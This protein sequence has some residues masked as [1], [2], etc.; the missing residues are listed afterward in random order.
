MTHQPTRPQNNLI[1]FRPR[2]DSFV[3]IDSDGCV[4]G[5][6]EIKQK[7]CF[8][9]L[10]IQ[11][12]H[13]EAIEPLVRE[14]LE[15]VNLYSQW[16]GTNRFLA[17]LKSF[18]LLRKRPEVIASGVSIPE[19][20]SFAAWTQG[21]PALSNPEL[22]RAVELTGSTELESVLVWSKAVNAEIARK[23]VNTHPFEWALKS[24]KEIQNHSDAVCVSQTPVEA[25]IREWANAG[26]INRVSCIAGQEMGTKSEHLALATEGKY[27]R[28]RVLMIGD[29][30]GDLDA[31]RANAALFY[32]INPSQ[33]EASWERFC[34][35][36]Y[37]RFLT[38]TYAGDYANGLISDFERL[39]P[40][41]PSWRQ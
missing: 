6:M 15:F 33:E 5:T 16:R 10:V 25:V 1:N 19:L 3:G 32:P 38:G 22:E 23:I 31:A 11:H 20:S 14:T 29:A 8:H 17:L 37:G 13:L 34:C 30:L 41:E 35:E 9:G 40:K 36:A 28:E 7:Q 21:T 39:L 27:F 2:H 24:L 18:E 4:L 26:I 12:F